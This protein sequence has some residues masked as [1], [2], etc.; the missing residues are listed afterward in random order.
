MSAATAIGGD[1]AWIMVAGPDEVVRFRLD[2]T[3]EREKIYGGGA[4]AMARAGDDVLL[5]YPDGG[6]EVLADRRR[7]TPGFTKEQAEVLFGATQYVKR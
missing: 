1:D 7:A 4:V 6:I 2:G 3:R 5:G